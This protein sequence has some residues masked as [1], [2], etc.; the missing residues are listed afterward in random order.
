M[1][2][3]ANIERFEELAKKILVALYEAF[4]GT[5]YPNP[6]NLGLIDTVPTR[7]AGGGQVASEE[8]RELE[9][10]LRTIL[11]WLVEQGLVHDRQ[12]R[13][14]ASH[15]LTLQGFAALE[16]LDPAYKA[17]KLVELLS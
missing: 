5:H 7:D 16:R 8:W 17:P 9:I 10:E 14:G 4:P 3:A 12:Y 15:V 2:M 6:K 11:F 13:A 1:N